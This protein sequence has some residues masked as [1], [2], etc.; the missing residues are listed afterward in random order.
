MRSPT[1]VFQSLLQVHSVIH[2]TT[3]KAKEMS[4]SRCS[5]LTSWLVSGLVD[6][7]LLHSLSHGKTILFRIAIF[8]FFLFSQLIKLMSC[9]SW[10]N[11]MFSS[12]EIFFCVARRS[13]S[14]SFCTEEPAGITSYEKGGRWKKG[15]RS[16]DMVLHFVVINVIFEEDREGEARHRLVS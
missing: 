7:S 1:F 12:W 8:H 9:L 3:M 16:S 13:I 14:F 15:Q 10:I 11:K 2:K 4:V 6:K 5:Y